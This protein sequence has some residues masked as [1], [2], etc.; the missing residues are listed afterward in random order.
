MTTLVHP[1]PMTASS[2]AR[3]SGTAAK[4]MSPRIRTTHAGEDGSLSMVIM[5]ALFFGAGNAS[6]LPSGPAGYTDARRPGAGLRLGRGPPTVHE[7][8]GQRRGV[9]AQR[10]VRELVDRRQQHVHR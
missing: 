10:T 4:S 9:V 1:S 5:C 7:L 2:A 8:H 6:N 3:S